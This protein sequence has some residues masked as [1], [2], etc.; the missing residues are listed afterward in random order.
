MKNIFKYKK[1]P[2]QYTKPW[3]FFFTYITLS[4]I[5]FYHAK[6]ELS[7][8]FSESSMFI[9]KIH[10]LQ[11]HAM[12]NMRSISP[13]CIL[14]LASVGSPFRI[15]CSTALLLDTFTRPAATSSFTFCRKLVSFSPI[16]VYYPRKI[17]DYCLIGDHTMK[18]E[19][20]HFK[21]GSAY[22]AT[23]EWCPTYWMNIGGCAAIAPGVFL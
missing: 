3:G 11:N 22:D 5:V 15:S 13:N 6:E 10:H 17:T 18:K 8:Y 12:N 16:V 23:Q 14:L 20:P 4:C 21:I 1:S 2:G 7:K 19:L 9:G